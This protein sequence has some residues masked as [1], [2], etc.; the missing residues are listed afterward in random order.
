MKQL[1]GPQYECLDDYDCVVQCMFH[2]VQD[3]VNMK[4]DPFYMEHVV[5][6]H[7]K[8]ADTKRSR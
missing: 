1:V 3:F 5:P 6:D 8:F 4:K 2:D 7:E